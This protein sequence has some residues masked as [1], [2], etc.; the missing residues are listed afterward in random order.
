[1]ADIRELSIVFHDQASARKARPYG[2]MGAVVAWQVS[3][4][5]PACPDDLTRSQLATRTPHLLQFTEQERG[6][7]VHIA[8][9]WQNKKGQRGHWSEIQSAIIP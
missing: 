4:T 5:A 8:L 3:Q 9:C 1:V 6:K 7:T 2:T